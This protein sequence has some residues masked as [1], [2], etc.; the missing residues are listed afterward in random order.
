MNS[1]GLALP[2][3]DYPLE[4][5]DDLAAFERMVAT[6][7]RQVAGVALR[8]LGNREDAR[9]AAQEV[10]LR[11]Y[12]HWHHIDPGRDLGG[13]LY[14]VTV[15]VCRDFE[16]RRPRLA[17]IDQV[18]EPAA[19]DADPQE[20]TSAAER[21]AVLRRALRALSPKERAA[22]V[23]RDVEGLSTGE[24]A[25]ILG[26]SEA[27]VRSQLSSARLKLREFAAR[28]TRRRT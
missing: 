14:R 17:A 11:L 27:T 4:R 8:L 2:V 9:D 1:D 20:E 3:T 16:R 28:L 6:Y 10:L 22:V 21:R 18:A 12:R 23:L 5:S 24:V 13:W 15:N 7:E 25:G 26:S 19:R